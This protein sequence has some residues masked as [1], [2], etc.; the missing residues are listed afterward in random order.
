MIG[1]RVQGTYEYDD[2]GLHITTD[3]G[4]EFDIPG[5]SG[6]RAAD[7]IDAEEGS[8]DFDIAE[9]E[10]SDLARGSFR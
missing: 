2:D 6:D 1:P 9:G 8:G 5:E 7:G 3:S 4:Q 10:W